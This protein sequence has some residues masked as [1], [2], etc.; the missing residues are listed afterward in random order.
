MFWVKLAISSLWVSIE[1]FD[2]K[3][4]GWHS[5]ES[6]LDRDIITQFEEKFTNTFRDFDDSLFW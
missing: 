4:D 3:G 2:C 1:G 5:V 6:N